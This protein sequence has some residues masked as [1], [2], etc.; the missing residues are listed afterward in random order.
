ME[1]TRTLAKDSKVGMSVN[2]QFTIRRDL[3]YSNVN[4][5]SLIHAHTVKEREGEGS[6]ARAHT[7][8]HTH[9]HTTSQHKLQWTT[10]TFQQ[11][12]L[13]AQYRVLL[14]YST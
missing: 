13:S 14:R 10:A 1:L 4:C 6:G 2:E 12:R 5:H 7:H 11:Q 8:T 9:T 3:N